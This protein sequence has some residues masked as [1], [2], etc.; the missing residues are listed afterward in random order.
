MI[1]FIMCMEKYRSGHN[2]A[3]SKSVCQFLAGTWVRIPPS[4]PL[5]NIRR[6]VKMERKKISLS[7]TGLIVVLIIVLGVIGYVLLK[8]QDNQEQNNNTSSL[9]EN[10]KVSNEEENVDN[11]EDV[12]IEENE[13][14]SVE[15]IK[16]QFQKYLDIMAINEGNGVEGV[17][18]YLKLLDKDAELLQTDEDGMVSTDIEYSTFEN[19]M[20]KVFSKDFF[21]TEFGN[22][23]KEVDGMLHYQYRGASGMMFEVVDIE[24]K[25]ELEY[26]A[27]VKAIYDEI[28]DD[29]KWTFTV[30]ENSDGDYVISSAELEE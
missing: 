1:L 2:E 26:I 10:N 21:N 20:L 11:E 29:E 28:E 9:N 23:I 30:E 7:F 18:K 25:D 3:D 16:E 22:S 12:D 8:K 4:P 17:L 5:I 27:S 19:E 15:E 6:G 24:S 14:V 13:D